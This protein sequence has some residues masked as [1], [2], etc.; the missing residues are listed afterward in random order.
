M[1]YDKEIIGKY[2]SLR[3]VEPEDAGATLA[4]RNDPKSAGRF[5][6]SVNNDVEKQAEWIRNQQKRPGDWFFV[7]IDNKTG[8]PVGTIGMIDVDAEKKIGWS[9]RL[10]GKGN[11]FQSFETQML[12]LDWGF[13]YLGLERI[14]GDID[15][16]NEPA[17]KFAKYFGWNFETPVFDEERGRRVIF[18]NMTKEDFEPA[19]RKLT[20]M[21]YR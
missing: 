19:R 14:R 12:I 1:K 2:V 13:D 16:N 6:H 5:F 9:S 15:E 4:M 7:A 10:I 8:E 20:K 11:A 3:A 18:V 21:I 17:L